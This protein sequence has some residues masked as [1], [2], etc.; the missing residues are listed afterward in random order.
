[1]DPWKAQKII[2]DIYYFLHKGERMD[3]SDIFDWDNIQNVWLISDTHF[4][5]NK[6]GE[7]CDRPCNWHKQIIENWN[8]VVSNDDIVLHLGDFSFRNQYYARIIRYMLK[9]DIYLIKG[10]HDR[11][12]IKWYENIG[13]ERIKPFYIY[14]GNKRIY[15]THRPYEPTQYEKCINICGHMH[16]NSPFMWQNKNGVKYANVSVE[17]TYYKPMKFK[18]LFSVLDKFNGMMYTM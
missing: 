12:G 2:D 7:Y 13:I 18:D 8:D 15:F 11:H 16:Q 5:H 6:I 10:N 17:Q 3:V 1:M 9:G 4:W 14:N